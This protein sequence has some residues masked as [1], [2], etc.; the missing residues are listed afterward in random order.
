MATSHIFSKFVVLLVARRFVRYLLYLSD[1]IY[2]EQFSF[3]NHREQ[4]GNP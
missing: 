1:L 2:L 4:Y 3:W